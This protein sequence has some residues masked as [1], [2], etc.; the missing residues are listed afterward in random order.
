MSVRVRNKDAKRNRGHPGLSA[1]A[2]GPGD[3]GLCLSG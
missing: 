1:F 3:P 2:P